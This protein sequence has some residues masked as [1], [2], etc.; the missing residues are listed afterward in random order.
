M[1]PVINGG[2]LLIPH[3]V[4]LINENGTELPD[5]PSAAVVVVVDVVVLPKRH[6]GNE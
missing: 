3:H 5:F 4:F 6:R 1:K 2:L